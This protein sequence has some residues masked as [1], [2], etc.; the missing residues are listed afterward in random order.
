MET[1]EPTETLA[2]ASSR[3]SP[4]SQALEPAVGAPD[5]LPAE[6]RVSGLGLSPKSAATAAPGTP[7]A[8]EPD[9]EE[10][11]VESPAQGKAGENPFLVGDFVWGKIKN[12]PWWPGQVYDPSQASDHA[13]I[14]HRKEHCLLVAYFGDDSFAW[15][16]PTQ[17][18]PFAA[19]FRQMAKQ[20]TAKSFVAAFG[21]ALDAIR[22]RLQSELTCHCIPAEGRAGLERHV[23]VDAESLITNYEPGKFLERLRDVA[24]DVSAADMLEATM[25]RSWASAF[26]KGSFSCG[27]FAYHPRRIIAD[28]VDKID[29]DAPPTDSIGEEPGQD[30][31]W[32]TGSWSV[33]KPEVSEDK[34]YRG[35]K[36]RSMAKLIAEMDLDAVE[37]SDGEEEKA[38][39]AVSPNRLSASKRKKKDESEKVLETVDVQNSGDSGLG[40]RERKKSKYLSPPYTFL[41]GYTKLSASPKNTESKTPKK[42]AEASWSL[43]SENPAILKCNSGVF[44][45][46]EEEEDEED[47]RSPVVKIDSMPASEILSEFL[48]TA[49]NPLH[50]KWNRSA[51]MVR[52][53]FTVYRSSVYS[54][55][56]DFG[57]YQKHLGDDGKSANKDTVDRPED[58]RSDG[59]KRRKGGAHEETPSGLGW[60]TTN[61][62][63]QAK[64]GLKRKMRK[65]G[66]NGVSPLDLGLDATDQ[67]EPGKA[68]PKRKMKKDGVTEETPLG[69]V[70]DATNA[71]EPGKTGSKGKMRKDPANIKAM[72]DLN[73]QIPN[74]WEE[75]KSPQQKKGNDGA[76]GERMVDLGH[77]R[78]SSAEA[79]K[80]GR[81]MIK[82][83]EVPNQKTPKESGPVLVDCVQGGKL[84]QKKGKDGPDS[85]TL[86]GLGM[87]FEI[88]NGMEAGKSGQKRKK[89]DVTT[90]R[91]PAALLLTFA[92]GITLPST[93]HLISTF[94]KYGDLIEAETEL[95]KE[96][97]CARVVFAKC[98]D[99]EKAL[100]SRDKS[101][102]FG[103]TVPSYRLCHL[104]GNLGSSP[105][106]IPIPKPPLPYIRKNLERM[107]S[108]LSG[109]SAREKDA[110]SS[111]GLKPEARENLVGEMRGLLKKVNKMLN[112]P[113][114]GVSS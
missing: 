61:H 92:P 99:A 68:G 18:R 64:S 60:G 72:L 7:A 8:A 69:S 56:S 47:K 94:R 15:C 114:A 110:G 52:G 101:E 62:S 86:V 54:R 75:R 23:A 107:I 50:L 63:E 104:P 109:S 74:G 30:E 46:A 100:N 39:E 90:Y 40:R 19:E 78:I 32:I 97:G 113:A 17:L 2:D 76:N 24:R 43:L 49:L 105:P 33:K 95:L 14:A 13:R 31:H 82:Y 96:S 5:P 108:T 58:G 44:R 81:K 84:G 51:K 6:P 16:E 80:T 41:S 57:V 37:L 71:S 98:T 102:A 112:G 53:F 106:Q 4:R 20:N 87:G 79:G 103:S 89:K 34:L 55:G 88:T 59:K 9:R 11:G 27:S 22:R 67:S 38:E 21:D 83:K 35:R 73:L 29:L 85:E 10:P 45:E 91:G 42:A 25:I 66:A 93:E 70:L 48:S 111:D 3:N 12:H 26:G 77:E 28:L 1:L 36:K 65:E